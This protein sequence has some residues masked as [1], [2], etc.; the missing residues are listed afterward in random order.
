M[1]GN[2]SGLAKTPPSAKS[3]RNKIAIASIY[4]GTEKRNPASRNLT[5]E[6]DNVN[7]TSACAAQ[8][9]LMKIC[10]TNGCDN[11]FSNFFFIKAP[12]QNSA[13]TSLSP[14]VP[15]NKFCQ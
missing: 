12:R 15:I 1:K 8:S 3:K 6:R 2:I 14:C 9:A 13:G 11:I 4:N 5:V 10:F 7:A